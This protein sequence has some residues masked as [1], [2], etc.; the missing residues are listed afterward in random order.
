V[1]PES[2][3][4]V[5]ALVNVGLALGVVGLT[6]HTFFT[7]HEAE[8]GEVPGA[9]DP[10]KIAVHVSFQ[11]NKAE[12]YS[13]VWGVLDKPKPVE[14]PQPVAAA[15]VQPED[16]NKFYQLVGVA[17]NEKDA[18]KSGVF[19]QKRV[20]GDQFSVSVGE[21]IES[22]KVTKIVEAPDGSVNVTVLDKTGKPTEV[23]LTKEQLKYTG[24]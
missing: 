18:T 24:G 2:G 16:I 12:Q 19:L 22:Y 4:L 9:L 8:P 17:I 14:A 6:Y 5:L 11:R 7:K 13:Q 1:K 3:R 21:E 10:Q 20:G 15:P 23:K